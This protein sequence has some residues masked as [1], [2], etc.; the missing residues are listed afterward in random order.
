[1]TDRHLKLDAA[2]VE[3]IVMVHNLVEIKQKLQLFESRKQ[4]NEDTKTR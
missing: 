1:M 2:S 4:R 3:I